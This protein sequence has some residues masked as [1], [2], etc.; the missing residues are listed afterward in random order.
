MDCAVIERI[1]LY[2]K[3]KGNRGFD[4]VRGV[5]LEGKPV[6]EVSGIMEKTHVPLCIV[7]PNCI[8]GYFKVLEPDKEWNMV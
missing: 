5:F 1:H 2:N 6:Y 8:K 3:E 4:S 7:N